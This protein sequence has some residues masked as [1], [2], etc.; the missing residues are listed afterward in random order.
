MTDYAE[1]V[2]Q[3]RHRF[4]AN[5]EQ[6]LGGIEAEIRRVEQGAPGAAADLHL[7]LHDLTGNAA[8]LGL[9][10]MTAEARRG[11][12]VLEGGRLEAEA[13]RAAALDDIRASVARLLE[14]KK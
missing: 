12:A 11:L 7:A 6:R 3:I 4:L 5:L 14:L 2:L 8:M 13:G 9:D 10:E 1:K